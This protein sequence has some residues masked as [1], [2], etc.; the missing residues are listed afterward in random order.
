MNHEEDSYF[1][2]NVYGTSVSGKLQDLS[3]YLRKERNTG[4]RLRFFRSINHK[5]KQVM[6]FLGQWSFKGALITISGFLVTLQ[7]E[8]TENAEF[9]HGLASLITLIV[10]VLTFIGICYRFYSWVDKKRLN[11]K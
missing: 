11:K 5:L 1:I 10:G 3:H 7:A 9:L 4:N 2:R 8:I 6:N